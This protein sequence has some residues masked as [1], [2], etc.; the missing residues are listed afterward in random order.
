[1]IAQNLKILVRK[2][3]ESHR[4]R[5]GRREIAWNYIR[6]HSIDLCGLC[7]LC[8]IKN[9]CLVAAAPRVSCTTNVQTL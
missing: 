7:G 5:R 8:E 6:K 1:M 4:A 3:H 2:S 9:L